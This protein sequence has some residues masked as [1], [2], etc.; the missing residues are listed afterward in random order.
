MD[1]LLGSIT[2]SSFNV[3]SSDLS[4][5]KSNL[6]NKENKFK[7]FATKRRVFLLRTDGQGPILKA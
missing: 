5:L 6:E 4:S 3:S 2:E 1:A 7:L